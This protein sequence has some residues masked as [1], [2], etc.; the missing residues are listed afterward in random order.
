M[1]WYGRYQ[2]SGKYDKDAIENIYAKLN[3]IYRRQTEWKKPLKRAFPS[4]ELLRKTYKKIKKQLE[5][6]RRSSLRKQNA[7]VEVEEEEDDP[8]MKILE[9]GSANI[10]LGIG[11]IKRKRQ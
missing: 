4:A 9:P 2:K 1:R 10:D 3:I 5:D 7:P 8:F 11:H 6:G